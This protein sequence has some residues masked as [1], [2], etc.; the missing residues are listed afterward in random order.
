MKTFFRTADTP[1]PSAP[2]SAQQ[3]SE[4]R[5][6]SA[7]DDFILVTCEHGGNRIPSRYRHLFNGHAA[8]LRS[9]RGYDAGALRFAREL[10]GALPAPLLACTISRLLIDL[11]RS[12]GHPKLYSEATRGIAPDLRQEI[13]S[14]YYLPY[15]EDAEA[16]IARA[17]AHGARVTHISCHSFTP[18]LDGKVRTADLGL[19][20]DPARAAEASLCRALRDA[21][22]AHAPALK[23]RLNYPYRGTAD[24]F[25]V[26]L[27]KRFPAER[28]LGIELEIN[29]AHVRK[30]GAHWH[31]MR[32]A[33][34]AGLQSVLTTSVERV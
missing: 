10:A 15:R 13:L 21:L 8:L 18:E 2:A 5:V 3:P 34:T 28:Y 16:R 1:R 23:V 14:R 11:N 30:G 27:R 17:I 6:L 12:R 22:R 26:Y 7:A 9:H 4:S 24:G 33:I 25:T 19:L 29:Q 20:Y 31:A 32:D